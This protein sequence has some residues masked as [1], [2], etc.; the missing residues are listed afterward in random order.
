[1]GFVVNIRIRR[2]G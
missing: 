2:I 1:M